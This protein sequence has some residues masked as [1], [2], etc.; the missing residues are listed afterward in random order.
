MIQLPY[1]KVKERI[2]EQ[3]KLSEKDIDARVRDKLTSLAG[4]ISK[5][6][7]I[8]I[9]ANELSVK[10][11][12]DRDKLKV[13]ELLAGMRGITIPLRVLRMYEL[14]EF[15]RN[16]KPGKVA[17]F[18]A[19]D[20]TGVVRVTLWNEQTDKFIGVVDGDTVL[21]KDATVKDNQGRLELHLQT[22]SE[23]VR[24]PVGIKVDASTAPVTGNF[25]PKKISELSGEPEYVDI[26]G[27]IVQVF[28][29]RSFAKKT[30]GEGLV[31]S[32]IIDDGTGTLR[33]SFWDDDA[34]ALLGDAVENTD[35]LADVKLE[36]LG[37]IVKVQGRSRLNPTYNTLEM[38]ASR[39]D[40]NPDPKAELARLG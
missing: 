39:L 20:E 13:K 19:G 23:L 11:I 7:A 22:G 38:S 1:E 30:G 37:Q 25:T 14:R 2:M 21:V 34:R 12:P 15:T 9:I 4:L 29:P 16:D 8:H 40:K 3:T 18:L 31:A 28:E 5:D 10:L 27:T 36:L 32:A 35:L 17:S 33:V 26:L 6:G 24:N